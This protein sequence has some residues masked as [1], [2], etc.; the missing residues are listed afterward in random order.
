M[1][2]ICQFSIPVITSVNTVEILKKG[3]KE[4]PGYFLPF[5]IERDAE[6]VS[7]YEYL[8]EIEDNYEES[9]P[10]PFTYFSISVQV[11][12]DFINDWRNNRELIYKKV[13]EELLQGELHLAS[14]NF[15]E[16]ESRIYFIKDYD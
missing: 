6:L 14:Y 1:Y 10:L 16:D 5:L 9:V 2:A 7:V 11:D 8:G 15:R 13:C 4:A 12:K 3:A